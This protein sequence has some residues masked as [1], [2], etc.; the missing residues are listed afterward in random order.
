MPKDI[1]VVRKMRFRVD[2][3]RGELSRALG[4]NPKVNVYRSS[5]LEAQS[6]DVFSKLQH[7]LSSIKCLRWTTTVLKRETTSTAACAFAARGKALQKRWE[8]SGLAAEPS[9]AEGQIREVRLCE[10][11]EPGLC[12]SRK[13]ISR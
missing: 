3:M 7:V 13:H 8:R 1:L 6:G 12:C 2:H 5:C 10:S 11:L 9:L 4:I